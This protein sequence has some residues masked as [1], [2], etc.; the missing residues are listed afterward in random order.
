MATFEELKL[1]YQLTHVKDNKMAFLVVGDFN[2]HP[3]SETMRIVVD[4]ADLRS[5]FDYE[6]FTKYYI[7][8]ERLIEVVDYVM[9]NFRGLDVMNE[10]TIPKLDTL[11][12]GLPNEK[13][14]S[15]HLSLYV[16]FAMN[17]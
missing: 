5:V 11:P 14:P 8:K 9:Y 1:E 13:Y 10:I 2:D 16:T 7:R 15:D 3:D 17:L 12:N 4:G 6:D